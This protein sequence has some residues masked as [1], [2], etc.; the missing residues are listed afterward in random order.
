LIADR[1]YATDVLTGLGIGFG[2]GYGVPVLLHYARRSKRELALTVEP[3][4]LGG[5]LALRGAF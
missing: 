5:C 2:I 4:C 1:H 3:G